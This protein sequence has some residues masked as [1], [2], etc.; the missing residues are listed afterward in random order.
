MTDR[1]L[2]QTR[3]RGQ[4]SIHRKPRSP[5]WNVAYY[6]HGKLH[7]EV[8]RHIRTGER[9]LA[10][11][12]NMTEAER[13]VRERIGAI[14]AEK[15]GAPSFVPPSRITVNDLLDDL[16]AEYKLGGKR[17]IPREVN[18]K[19]ASNVKRVSEYFGSWRAASVRREHVV[20]YI[21]EMRAAGKSNATVNRRTQLLGQAFRIAAKADPPKVSREINIPKLD[22]SDN[23]R[24]GKFTP[25]EAELVA[26]SLPAYLADF[27]RFAYE[28]GA[29]AGEI[30][31]LRWSYITD[32]AIKVPAADTK[33]RTARVIAIT[34]ELKAILDRRAADRRPGCEFIFHHE[35]SAIVDY[36]RAWQTACVI[37]GLGHFE[38]QACSTVLDAERRCPDCGKKPDRPLYVG[39]LFHDFRRSAAH[40]MWKAG[41]S[42]EDCMKTTGHQTS[43]MFKRYADLF[44]E[45]EERARQLEVQERRRQWRESQP[46]SQ[47]HGNLVVMMPGKAS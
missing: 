23:R 29:R 42:I 47:P 39:R 11:E 22:E 27:A 13:F 19:F 9:L 16:V 2:K 6:A 26:A 15:F 45:D 20:R 8:A 34:P 10:T 40:E 21:E 1:A 17:G 24:T 37:N 5:Y 30:L 33:A 44:S 31:K 38:C 46:K 28:T 41:S 35:G 36:R 3:N 25:V 14:K 32:G 18:A 43:S 4:G 7:R 12:K